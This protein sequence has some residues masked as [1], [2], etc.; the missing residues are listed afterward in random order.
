M[1]KVVIITGASNGIGLSLAETLAENG[2]IVFNLDIVYPN[3]IG[4]GIFI[5]CDIRDYKQIESA[6][7]EME[8]I[9]CDIN[10]DYK[11]ISLVNNAGVNYLDW[12]DKISQLDFNRV[13]DTNVKGTFFTTQVFLPM[14]AKHKSSVINVVSN[15]ADKPMTCSSVYNASKGAV[16]IL[17]REMAR[18]LTPKFGI[19]VFGISP[20]KILDTMMSEYVDE[21]VPDIRGWTKEHAQEYEINGIPCRENTPLKVFT[22][23]LA[24]LVMLEDDNKYMSGNIIEYGV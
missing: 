2:Y 5:K 20:N 24:Y 14:L 23:H 7:R 15:A 18:E 1:N 19:T 9:A 3:K 10:P 11:L 22:D 17:T 6:K 12:F 16:K 4:G 21:V 8:K 13:I